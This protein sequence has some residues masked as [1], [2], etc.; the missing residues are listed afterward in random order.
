VSEQPKLGQ[1]PDSTAARDA[2]HIAITPVTSA[3]RLFPGQHVGLIPGTSDRVTTAAPHIG[4]VDPYLTAPVQPGQRFYLCLYPQTVTSLR[5]EWT[6]PAFGVASVAPV[7]AA[8][9]AAPPR[10]GFWRTPTVLSMCQQIREKRDHYALPILADAL[11]DAGYADADI[12]AK[13]RETPHNAGRANEAARLACL[14][15]GGERAEAVEWLDNLAA[16]LDITYNA[17]MEAADAWVLHGDYTTQYG[18]EWWR[19]T[20]DCSRAPHFWQRYEIVTGRKPESET[21]TF[22]SCSC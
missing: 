2:I 9:K 21:D 19:D 11:E 7:A 16:E 3:E 5:H 6:H 13:L 20:L 18:S 4:I 15:E 17:L 14:I 10:P 1:T 12:L 22:F 8:A